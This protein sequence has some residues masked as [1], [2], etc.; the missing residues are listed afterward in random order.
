MNPTEYETVDLIED[1][2]QLL[3]TR[4]IEKE[5]KEA[6]KAYLTAHLENNYPLIVVDKELWEEIKGELENPEEDSVLDVLSP[7]D[8]LFRL[9]HN[10]VDT[11]GDAG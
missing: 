2:A 8:I 3:R 11:G 4:T 6:V 9:R 7:D 10:K 1:L 5:L